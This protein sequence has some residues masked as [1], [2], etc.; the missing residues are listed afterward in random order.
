MPLQTAENKP[1][2]PIPFEPLAPTDYPKPYVIENFEDWP[3][4]KLGQEREEFMA[5]AT[6]TI[7][8][9]I[10]AQKRSNSLSDEIAK[11]LYLERIR[12]VENP[13]KV[14]PPDEL[15]FWNDIRKKLLKKSLDQTEQAV[16]ENN[17]KLLS[18]IV[19][20]YLRE[21][22]SKFKVSTYRVARQL[23]PRVFNILLS[24]SKFFRSNKHL[25]DRLQILGQIETIRSLTKKGTVILVPTH[26]SNLDSVLIG[27][28][29]DRVGLSAFS[30][31]AGINLY[32]TSILGYMFP[33]LGAYG[34]DRRKKN[35][36]YLE[37]LKA[38]SQ[39][40]IERGVHSLFFPGGTRSRSGALEK[41]LKMGLMGTAID[42]QNALL[43]RKED[44]K[45]FIVPVVL[46]YHFVLEA[47]SL[48]DSHLKQTGKELYLIEKKAFGGFFNVI[49]FFWN[50]F[51]ASSNIAVN[52]GQP[53]DVLGNFVDAEGTSIS[54]FGHEVDIKDYFTSN[55]K[56]KYDHQRNGQY[57]QMLAD[58]IVERYFIENIVLSSHLVAYVAF[59]IFQK[60]YPNLDLYGLLRLPKED[61]VILKKVFY[62][63]IEH[64]RNRLFEL[65]KENK[66]QLSPEVKNDSIEDLII[67]GINNVGNFHVKRAL[68]L[69]KENDIRSEDMNLLLYYHNRMKGYGLSNT[70][71]A[72]IPITSA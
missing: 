16:A 54:Q 23:L 72:Q 61:R 49:K 20:R 12:I 67:H 47:K 22:T 58:K 7:T 56:I 18:R 69:D 70:I 13:W 57:T 26:F 24:A 30:Y 33:R 11:A 40:T 48:I 66:L 44:N 6:Q 60:Q 8:N 35:S 41:K 9:R 4:S 15:D 17:E 3:I 14:D 46:N 19:E 52:Y 65:E 55:G 50:F 2:L 53:M 31:G 39:L 63:N 51:R 29:S 10:L 59:N 68:L 43:E 1:I 37:T 32:N 42:A 71:V 28:A 25:R 27:W 64:L 34:V 45:I 36:F 21:I 5:Q 38:Y 62:Y